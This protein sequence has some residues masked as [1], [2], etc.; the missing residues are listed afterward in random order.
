MKRVWLVVR[1][2]IRAVRKANDE[3][4][5]MWER[6][7]L[8]SRA[9]PASATG[10]L[11]WVP[12]LDGYRLAGG[13]LPTQDPDW[14][15][16]IIGQLAYAPGHGQRFRHLALTGHGKKQP[17]PFRKILIVPN[18]PRLTLSG[19]PRSGHRAG[20]RDAGLP[21]PRAEPGR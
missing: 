12:S 18:G 8:S 1:T 4:V 17:G 3:Q 2:V 19:L 9:A 15:P 21:R 13:R 20:R 16:P 10:R 5:Y 14:P 11:C 6:L 7:A